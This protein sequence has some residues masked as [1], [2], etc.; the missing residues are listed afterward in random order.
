MK[1]IKLWL[2]TIATLWCSLTASAYDFYANG[3]RYNITSE[4]TVS[5]TYN[6][7]VVSRG[8]VY[9]NFHTKYS[10]SV[11]IPSTVTN[12]SKTY[13]VT[14]IRNNA[15]RDCKSL[16][17]ITLPEGVTSIG[18]NAFRDCESLTAITIPESV[19]SIGDEAF[20]NC[21]SLTSITLP[22]G[23]T[24]IG[25][26]AFYWC[27]SLTSI[28]LPEGVTS[29]GDEAFYNCS[30]LTAV[31]IK[32][33]TS[34][35]NIDFGETYSNPLYYAKNLYLNSE[36]VT[37]L[38]SP[39]AVA[40]IK[41]Y[42]FYNCSSLTS[43]TIPESVT[44]IGSSAF[45]NCS[46]LTSITIP[47]SVTSIGSSAFRYCSR[48][49]AVHIKDIASWCNIDFGDAYSNPLYY[50]TN[51]YMNSELV[52]TEQLTIPNTV[53]AIKSYAFY[54][55][56]HSVTIGSGVLSIGENAFNYPEKVIWMTNTPPTGYTN[57]NGIINYVANDQYTGLSNVKV[58]PYLS[59][60]FEVDGVKYVPV[61]PSE[62]T[63]HAIDC[64]Y[65]DAVATINVGETASFK[66]V[67]MKVTEVMPFTFYGN[68]HIKEV[69][70]SHLGNIGDYAFF[71]CD[72]IET[73]NVKNQGNIGYQAFYNCS[74]IKSVEA[75]NNGDIGEQAFYNCDAIET[76]TVSNQGS[77]GSQAFYDCD[78][79]KS[80]DIRNQ[81]NIGSQAFYGCNGMQ[82]ANIA[83][84]A[85]ATPSVLTFVDWTSTNKTHS[86]TSSETYTFTAGEGATLSFNW[87]VSSEASYDKLIVTLDG[88]TILEK[89]G[90]LSGTYSN[91]ISKGSHTL[92]V[93]YTKDSSNSSGSDQAKVSNITVTT[94][95]IAGVGCEAF[96]G[97][98][99]LKTA[100]LGD[101]I[102]S[103]GHKAFYQ[104]S[105]LQEIAIPDSVKSVDSYCFSGCSAM[106]SAVI[107][108][109][110]TDIKEYT[111]ADCRLEEI[112]IG[113]NI[114]S[115][116]D[117]AFKGCTGMKHA[118]LGNGLTIV[119]GTMF[120]GCIGLEKVE[121]GNKIR[122]LAANAF[123]GCSALKDVALGSSVATINDYAFQNCSSLPEITLP[124][125]VTKVGD[126]VFSGCSKL[127]DVMIA[128]RTTPLALG[129][130][131][132]SP[133]FV[134]CPLDSVYIGG[135]ITYSTTSSKGYSPFYRNTSLRTVVITDREEQIYNNEFYGCTNLKNVTIGNGVKS[136][137][138]YAFSGCSSLD[139]FA[140][141]S[142]MQ[143]IGEEAF[144]DCTN[145]TEICS[146][147]MNPPTCGT[148]ALDDIN[149]WNCILKVPTGYM[150]A[151]QAADQ[152]KEF[153]FIEDIV[154]VVTYT[155]TFMVD[156]EV[157]H[158]VELPCEAAVT[159]PDTPTKEGHTFSGWDKT[160]STMP[161]EDVTISG[162]FTINKYLVTFKVDGEIVYSESLEYGASIVAPDAPEKEGH[163]FNGWGEVN[164]TVPAH[165]VTYEANYSVN[166]YQLTYV[167]DGETVQTESVAYG[168]AITLIDEPVK[169]GYTFSGWGEVPETMPAHDVT[170]NGTFT[171]NKYL[172]TFTVDGAVI[173]SDSLEYGTAISVPTMPE[174]E[175]YTFS[176]WSEVAETVPAHDVTYDASY[177]ANIYKVYYFV[178]ATLV[179][180]AEVAYGE[181]IPEY[182]YE[183]TAE[184]DVFLGWVGESYETMPAHD[185]TYT[186]NITN[187]VLQWA[188]DNGQLT[189]Y[190]LSGRKI[191][192][193][194]LRELCEGIYIINGQKVVINNK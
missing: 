68:D 91:T 56:L 129:S 193:D 158:T 95:L 35:C 100:T 121:M 15:F 13:S 3:I 84:I 53:A 80:V 1:T 172:V 42:A 135:K 159:M 72:A 119:N 194:D 109:G 140:F 36:L 28:T 34:W 169:E 186:A 164:T 98:S 137:G 183:P 27:K 105:S 63:C 143:R 43:I 108:N 106:K 139:K 152:W 124:R 23:V 19:T 54:G 150:A 55:R 22:E 117:Y 59:S 175:G 85:S 115:I 60:M 83:N 178:G 181:A 78:G 168:T 146:S 50:A 138:N 120:S 190:D 147:A 12:G 46:S 157:Y 76:V 7:S 187:D 81:G 41:D 151:Y 66:G 82:V 58:Y 69:S 30:S 20:Y 156:G 177:T 8:S 142:S 47:E 9:F 126:Y 128:D 191:E 116:G 188:I 174:R 10:G 154:E 161:A 62:R 79:I 31:H 25:D 64:V 122:T 180:T 123:S 86:S 189:I 99:S 93:K 104:C 133:L 112:L 39:N 5:V 160:L 110:L 45:Y 165:D 192:V 96:S 130:N 2:T 40:A 163:T 134:D 182:I 17:S 38:A 4:T 149:K 67:A 102:G 52:T 167:V 155:L 90:S 148:Q 18:N 89:S 71:D 185:V 33:I 73:V 87:S 171:I 77:I 44:S 173:A 51:L 61:S 94:T 29:I 179:H 101:S 153:F 144:S 184:G 118:V 127:A 24:S 136:I 74:G 114:T 131:D 97:C 26:K 21:S 113:D 11:V 65:D 176:G 132:S 48:L 107:G 125:A 103:L 49:T 32:D 111:F 57:V 70:V 88:T 6:D 92:V 75:A 145:L 166:S 141:G 162:T 14:S 16:T 37:E 170:L